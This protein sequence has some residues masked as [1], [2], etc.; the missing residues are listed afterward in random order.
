MAVAGLLEVV[1]GRGGGDIGRGLPQIVGVAD[2]RFII[3]KLECLTVDHVGQHRH[4]LR[5]VRDVVL[6]AAKRWLRSASHFVSRSWWA[7]LIRC[8]S[9]GR[10][11]TFDQSATAAS[12]LGDLRPAAADEVGEVLL[13]CE[14]FAIRLIGA[15]LAVV[16]GGCKER[17]V[18]RRQHPS[19]GRRRRTGRSR[20]RAPPTR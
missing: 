12:A 18:S 10:A 15:D 16:T 11:A 17:S 13:A 7:M 20:R 8:M 9:G 2:E 6:I 3:R 19:S 1:R 4:D 5:F 14:R